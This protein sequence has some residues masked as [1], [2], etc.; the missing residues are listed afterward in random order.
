MAQE[1]AKSESATAGTEDKAKNPLEAMTRLREEK[2]SEGSPE[3]PLPKRTSLAERLKAEQRKREGGS[4][5]AERADAKRDEPPKLKREEPPKQPDETA[6][7]K[8]PLEFAEERFENNE[9][10]TRA[11]NHGLRLAT[12]DIVLFLNND[13]YATEEGWLETICDET[14]P[15]VL[16]GA[17]IR[18]DAHGAVDGQALPYLDGW[19]LAGMRDD[20]L[21][22]SGFD[23]GFEEPAY[24]SDNDLCLRA[25]AAGMTLREVR[26]GL[27]HKLNATAGSEPA[28]R[29]VSVRNYLRFARRARKLMAVA[30]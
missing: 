30:A 6:A 4:G 24:Y 12:S 26:V 8:P 10:F 25:R 28:N 27:V 29:E 11:S 3:R 22:L 21:A 17:K 18:R 9:G 19:C 13:I 7:A 5:L 2:A 23:E 20:L 16:T 1:Q 14:E 15:G